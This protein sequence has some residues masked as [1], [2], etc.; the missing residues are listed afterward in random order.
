M[1]IDEQIVLVTGAGRGLG[2]AIATAFAREGAQVV[3]NYR[4]SADAAKALCDSLG[5]RALAIKVTT[6]DGGPIGFWRATLRTLAKYLSAAILMIG[7]IMAGFTRRK[8][9]LHDYIAG[10]LVIDA[11]T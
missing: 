2:S 11:K 8:Q 1:K 4:K 10:T 7:F 5:K 9:A 6:L 3:V